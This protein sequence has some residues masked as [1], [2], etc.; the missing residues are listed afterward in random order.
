MLRAVNRRQFRCK[1]YLIRDSSC[2]PQYRHDAGGARSTEILRQAERIPFDLPLACF[3]PNLLRDVTD[4]PYA[5]G[6]HWMT[7]RLQSAAGIHRPLAL[8]AGPAGQGVWA[9]FA[10]LHETQIFD[11]D[12]LRDGE[13]VVHFGELYVRWLHAGHLVSLLGRSL[14]GAE[15]GDVSFFIQGNVVGGLRNSK[16]AD[17]LVGELRGALEWRDQHR[18]RAIADERAIVNRE[19]L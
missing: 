4:L 2:S 6:A 1:R 15:C 11:S 12:D 10:F 13:T 5:R 7:L 17:E 14:D 19:R 3:A 8:N 9:A 18:S 16:H